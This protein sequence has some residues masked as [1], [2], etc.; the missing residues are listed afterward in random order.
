VALVFFAAMFGNAAY[1]GTLLEDSIR[2]FFQHPVAL[3]VFGAMTIPG[4][5]LMFWNDIARLRNKR[6]GLYLKN[7]HH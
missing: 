4:I 6:D 5:L 1:S 7:Y 3:L 2:W